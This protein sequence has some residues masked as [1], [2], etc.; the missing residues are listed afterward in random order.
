M[1]LE[2]LQE[3]FRLSN[4]LGRPRYIYF[5]QDPL[6]ALS[7]YLFLREEKV[8]SL[9]QP[10]IVNFSLKSVNLDVEKLSRLLQIALFY[11]KLCI[12]VI[13]CDA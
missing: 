13:V 4:V 11:F 5:Q 8:H 6:V 2:K 7:L 12:Y 3:Y 9:T 1:P 10:V